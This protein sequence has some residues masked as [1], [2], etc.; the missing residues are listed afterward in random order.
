M[1]EKTLMQTSDYK[2]TYEKIRGRDY[3]FL[4]EKQ[5]IQK[6]VRN[7]WEE[8]MQVYNELKSENK[9]E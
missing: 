4:S 9:E 1:A 3:F 8:I 6:T 5:F 7:T 2:I